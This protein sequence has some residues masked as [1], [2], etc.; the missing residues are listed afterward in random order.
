MLQFCQH[1]NST[2]KNFEIDYSAFFTTL[3]DTKHVFLQRSRTN[4]VESKVVQDIDY[5]L[6]RQIIWYSIN[7]GPVKWQSSIILIFRGFRCFWQNFL[8][9]D[10]CCSCIRLLTYDAAF[11]N[12]LIIRPCCFAKICKWHLQK[13]LRWRSHVFYW[14]CLG[15]QDICCWLWPCRKHWSPLYDML[16]PKQAAHA[17][18]RSA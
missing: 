18:I 16:S 11:V 3:Y 8:A 6:K 9:I 1:S 10:R 7:T 12:G 17:R 14:S 15:C 2:S 5:L 4:S 13:F